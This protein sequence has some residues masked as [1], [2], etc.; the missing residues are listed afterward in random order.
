LLQGRYGQPHAIEDPA[1]EHSIRQAVLAADSVLAP[2]IN[3]SPDADKRLGH[4]EG[5][6]R[7]ASRLAFLLFSQPS[8]WAF[9]WTTGVGMQQSGQVVIF[10]GLLETVSDEGLV[11]RPPR[12]FSEPEVA[13]V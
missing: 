11:R 2:F 9:E 13:A 7:R 1:L 12:V 5:I 3:G 8:S 10:P 6:V 4:L